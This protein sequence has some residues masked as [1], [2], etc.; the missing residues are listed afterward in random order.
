MSVDTNPGHSGGKSEESEETTRR[1]YLTVGGAVAVALLSGCSGDDASTGDADSDDETADTETVD[2]GVDDGDDETETADAEPEDGGAETDPETVTDAD[3]EQSDG[4]SETGT[5]RDWETPTAGDNFE[6]EGY[7]EDS[8]R[9]IDFQHR[10]HGDDFYWRYVQDN[11]DVMELYQVDGTMYI[12]SDESCFVRNDP[13]IYVPEQPD[14][15]EP[16]FWDDK[17]VVRTEQL[18]GIEVEVYEFDTRTS[19]YRS[20]HTIYVRVDSGYV[21]RIE[22]YVPEEDALSV[23]T[24]HSWG[25]ATPVSEPEMDCQS[26]NF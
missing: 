11:G 25:E 10:T 22:Q 14:F 19:S 5:D 18:D 4:E 15:S 12:V 7:L 24:L 6:M 8:E 2:A 21:Y 23:G 16:E 3:G 9:V 20:E 1:R 26:T 13:D 17:E